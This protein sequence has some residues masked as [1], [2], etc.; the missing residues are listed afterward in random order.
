MYSKNSFGNFYPVDS[1]IH[2]LNPVVKF[3][4]FIISMVLICLTMSLRIHIFLI[5]LSVQPSTLNKT[6]RKV[7]KTDRIHSLRFT[8]SQDISSPSNF[9]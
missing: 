2:R 5:V 6:D 9:S 4:N 3:L 7:C 8:E 1:S